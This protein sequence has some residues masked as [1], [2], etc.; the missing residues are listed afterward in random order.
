MATMDAERLFASAKVREA[1]IMSDAYSRTL[2]ALAPANFL[3]VAGAALLS[4]VAGATVLAGTLSAMHIG[5]IALLSSALTTIHSKL[6]CERYQA[7]CHQMQSWYKGIAQDYENLSL[8]DDGD[9]L[10]ER[11]GQLNDQLASAMKGAS[12]EPFAWALRKAQGSAP[13]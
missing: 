10:H 3:L 5:V 4:L 7:E 2:S 11:L 9:E 8:L 6:G 13:H 12:A 1:R